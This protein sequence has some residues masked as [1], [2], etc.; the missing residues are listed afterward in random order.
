MRVPLISNKDPS[1]V[2]LFEAPCHH[3]G[4]QWFLFF[5]HC[6]LIQ[7]IKLKNADISLIKLKNE[8]FSNK[9]ISN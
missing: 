9:I 8:I 3:A 7:M 4:L 2:R 6:I 1:F 5:S